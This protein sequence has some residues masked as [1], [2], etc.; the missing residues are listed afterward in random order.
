MLRFSVVERKNKQTGI[1]ITT[2][3]ELATESSLFVDKTLLIKDFLE[4]PAKVLAKY[5]P[6]RWGKSIN[7]SM[8]KTFL[9][10]EVDDK[11]NEIDKAKTTN[12]ELFHRKLK[13]SNIKTKNEKQLLQ[14]AQDNHLM[15]TYQGEYPVIYID[16]T[17]KGSNYKEIENNVKLALHN[18]VT[19]HQYVTYRL[20]KIAKDKKVNTIKRKKQSISLKNSKG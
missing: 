6:R 17:M 13:S 3:K 19:K 5:C 14:I 16:F 1:G 8:I 7:M 15:Q 20:N 9:E 18:A 11:G 2:F 12:Y 4:H 10:I